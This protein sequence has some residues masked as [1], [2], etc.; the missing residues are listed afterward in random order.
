MAEIE[1]KTSSQPDAPEYKP[2]PPELNLRF[3]KKHDVQ[4]EGVDGIGLNEEVTVVVRGKV[5]RLE[6]YSGGEYASQSIGLEIKSCRFDDGGRSSKK[7][8]G[9]GEAVERGRK[10]VEED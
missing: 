1:I 8:I 3:D 2:S 4:P 7:A 5:T 10:Y 6:S 9:L